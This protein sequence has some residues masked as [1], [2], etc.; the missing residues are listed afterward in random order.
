MTPRALPGRGGGRRETADTWT[1]ELEPRG[2][3][4]ARLRS[5]PGQ[6]NMLYAFG[7]RRGADLDQRRSRRRRRRCCTRC[8]RSG[9]VD[10][11]DL[12]SAA[13]ATMLG[14]RGPFGSAWPLE[15]PRAA[16]CSI[17]AGGIGLAPLRPASTSAL[18]RRASASGGSPLLYGGR[19]P[20]Q[21]LYRE[22]ARRSGARDPASTSA[23]PSTARPRAGAGHVGR[24]ARR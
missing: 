6:F 22:R 24:R 20:E 11:G 4:S 5:R 21:L 8:G 3:R 10:R 15:R 1:L 16:T 18:A 17:V 19:A 13:R 12:R 23:S 7:G 2:R 14:V 9:A